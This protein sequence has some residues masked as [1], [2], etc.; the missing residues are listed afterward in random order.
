MTT[1]FSWHCLLDALWFYQQTYTAVDGLSCYNFKVLLSMQAYMRL[2]AYGSALQCA[3]SCVDLEDAG[4]SKAAA[5][6]AQAAML[7]GL[8]DLALQYARRARTVDQGSPDFV[9]LTDTAAL[10]LRF[11]ALVNGL[12]PGN[13]HH[14]Q[15]S[16]RGSDAADM[17]APLLSALADDDTLQQPAPSGDEEL[18]GPDTGVEGLMAQ[19]AKVECLERLMLPS[20]ALMIACLRA[21]LEAAVQ[22]HRCHDRF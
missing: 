2:S 19:L 3:A 4:T 12:Q 18:P 14:Q 1:P 9:A 17:V 13:D 20:V 16:A 15:G 11:E 21:R 22:P 7:S 5:L 10:Q 6:A 8:P